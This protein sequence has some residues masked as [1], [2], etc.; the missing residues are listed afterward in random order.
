MANKGVP[1]L[2]SLSFLAELNRKKKSN[3]SKVLILPA[4]FTYIAVYS[5]KA[6]PLQWSLSIFILIGSD[7]IHRINL[8]NKDDF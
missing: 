4:P 6:I 5:V 3:I 1:R 7:L 8:R 2:V